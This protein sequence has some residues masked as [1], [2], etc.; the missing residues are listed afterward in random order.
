MKGGGLSFH[1]LPYTKIEVM[2]YTRERGERG[3]M[4]EE[5]GGKGPGQGR[6]LEFRND[7]AVPPQRRIP[8]LGRG[9]V[10]KIGGKNQLKQEKRGNLREK[11]QRNA[12]CS[13]KARASQ[14]KKKRRR[15]GPPDRDFR[16]REEKTTV[17]KCSFGR[18]GATGQDALKGEGGTKQQT[19]L[20]KRCCLEWEPGILS[21][22]F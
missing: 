21:S 1:S 5:I 6:P 20:P 9:K 2:R 11:A 16:T 12:I 13:R 8:P 4:G 10:M 17:A 15:A 18:E 14:R 7:S 3:L 19:L 22:P